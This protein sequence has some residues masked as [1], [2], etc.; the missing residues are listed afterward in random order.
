MKK[1]G[2]VTRL[3]REAFEG[4]RGE[5]RPCVVFDERLDCVRVVA[6]DCSIMETR[7]NS[8]ITILEDNYY[9][10]SGGKRFV[11]FTIKG[12]RYFCD[13]HGLNT[14]SPITLSAIL[15]KILAVSPE[16][17]VQ[18]FIDGIA[19]PLIEQEQIEDRIDF[20]TPTLQGV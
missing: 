18:I 17:V 19:R 10:G 1:Q 14:S 6:R 4:T 20:S 11:G 7:L 12:A 15:D 5:F 13:T 3:V 16:L 9:P 2:E 8:L